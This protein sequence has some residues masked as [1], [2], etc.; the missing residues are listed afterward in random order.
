MPAKRIAVIGGGAKAAAIAAKAHC[1]N[2]AGCGE[3]QV[4]IFEQGLVGQNWSGRAGFTDGAQ[5]L[6]TP[7]ERDLGF[8]YE[9]TIDEDVA[10]LMQE[11]FSWMAFAVQDRDVAYADWIDRSQRRPTHAEFSGYLRFAIARS[12]A[13]L[14]EKTPVTSL[15]R[16]DNC[17]W[18][19]TSRSTKKEGPFD[20]VVVTGPGPARTSF[21]GKS[22][23][24]LFDCADF[25]SRLKAVDTALRTAKHEPV[26]IVGGG[27]AAAASAAWFVRHFP[28]REIVII[29]QQPT[30][31]TRTDSYLEARVFSD[32]EI[33][34]RLGAQDKLDFVD[35]LTRAVV[36][37]AVSKVLQ[38]AVKLS[39]VPGR[40]IDF[41]RRPAGSGGPSMPMVTY[42]TAVARKLADMEA[43]LVVDAA[44]FDPWRVF[45][46]L[47]PNASRQSIEKGAKGMDSALRLA[48][49]RF[50]NLHAPGVS[51]MQGPGYTS[52]MVLGR[53]SD[54]ILR[55]YT[56][57]RTRP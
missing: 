28:A 52:L 4:T 22:D 57:P 44:G 30:F 39:F 50:P 21:P 29:A 10:R 38:D 43:S 33:W 55:P 16:M 24:A 13:D 34:E 51:Q 20:G 37:E 18:V 14:R 45:T 1:V 25:W 35:R 7:A 46:D 5:L 3:I 2:E 32:D 40:A 12:G 48:S 42:R 53:M 54:R 31:Y 27:G 17:W 36:W 26:V 41:Q 23:R 11:R 15:R 9:S 56:T 49:T 19:G 6:C 47:L 8:P